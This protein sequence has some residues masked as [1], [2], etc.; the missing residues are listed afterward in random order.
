[1]KGKITKAVIL[2]A[3]TLYLTAC[4]ANQP[5]EV[6]PT[7]T[8]SP[9]AEP[10]AL[11]SSTPTLTFTPTVTPTYTPT[12][13]PT[14]A[15]VERITFSP[16]VVEHRPSS[17]FLTKISFVNSDGSGLEFPTLFE[18][19]HQDAAR[20]PI[21]R[22]LVWSPDGRYLAF[23]GSDTMGRCENAPNTDC[24]T[25]NYGTVI[26]DYSQNVILHHIEDTLTN[27]SWSPDSHNLVL[28]ID[29]NSDSPGRI[30]DLYILNINNGQ[31][32]QLTSSPLND[33]FPSWSP[34]GQWI[35]FVRFDPS[36]PGCGSYPITLF[37]EEKCSQA[38]LY[39]IRPN[40]SDL[41]LLFEPIFIYSLASWYY[42]PNNTP[43]WSPDSR[44]LAFLTKNEHGFYDSSY[45]SIINIE[46][47]YWRTVD[48]EKDLN[49]SPVWSPDGQKLAFTGDQEIY[50]WDMNENSRIN[51]TT[52]SQG[53]SP[54]WSLSGNYIAFISD[55]NLVIM[56]VDGTNKVTIDD[57]DLGWVRSRPAWQPGVQP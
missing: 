13:T 34:D 28:S 25:T 1:M 18:P 14:P 43:T 8:L 53:V 16:A 44:S 42:I 2:I 19:Y 10:T 23:D 51:I 39:M 24:F 54:T 36:V 20:V 40:G 30:G 46:T 52:P 26:A 12:F 47:G 38:S 6:V 31:L 57:E 55:G 32:E 56:N 5:S 35:A 29:D 45:I 15:P 41:Q 21:G 49:I 48:S 33:L 7:A 3:L 27:T 17:F 4:A 22:Y 11:P 50:L 37:E 9:S